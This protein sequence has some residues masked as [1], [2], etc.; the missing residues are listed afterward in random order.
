MTMKQLLSDA[1]LSIFN[2]AAGISKFMGIKMHSA[3]EIDQTVR[4]LRAVQGSGLLIGGIAVIHHGYRRYT[5]DVD[6]LYANH[7]TEIVK[8]LKTNFKAVLKAKSGWHHFE[9]R[10]THVRLELIPEGGLGTYGFIPGPKTV[11]GEDGFISLHGLIWLKLVAGRMQDEA[12]IAE[13]A[14]NNLKAVAAV[15]AKLPPE[16]HER[17]DALIAR[18]KKEI[19]T[20]PNRHA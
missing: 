16:H 2:F 14:K 8:R 1:D 5:D 17:F 15:R 4:D 19:E 11:G 10:K 13:I 20:D 9:H 7:D 18:A 12:D 3:E 6:M